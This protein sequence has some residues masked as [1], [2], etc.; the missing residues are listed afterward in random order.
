MRIAIDGVKSVENLLNCTA[1][2]LD[3]EYKA[4]RSSHGLLKKCDQLQR[5]ILRNITNGGNIPLSIGSNNT[6]VTNYCF[7]LPRF[8][9]RID[10][11]LGATVELYGPAGS[12]KTRAACTLCVEFLRQFPT[13]NAL[14]IDAEGGFSQN[15]IS[16][17]LPDI[18]RRLFTMRVT[19]KRCLWKQLSS[20]LF[21]NEV[22]MCLL[23]L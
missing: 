21:R 5:E 20:V 3:R 12:G 16:K 8:T 14:Y 15:L 2:D 7:K 11:L 10:R 1:E 4:S 22:K 18:S 17:L 13:A 6:H 19:T 9:G 23:Y